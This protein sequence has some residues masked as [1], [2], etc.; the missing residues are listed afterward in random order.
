MYN[1]NLHFYNRTTHN[2]NIKSDSNKQISPAHLGQIS[3]VAP[4]MFQEIDFK[5]TLKHFGRKTAHSSG[6][7]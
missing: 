6:V 2:E 5:Q 7:F 1:T 3:E 4:L